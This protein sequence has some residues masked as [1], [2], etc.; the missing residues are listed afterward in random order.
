MTLFG[1]LLRSNP[2][3]INQGVNSPGTAEMIT[4]NPFTQTPVEGVNWSTRTGAGGS[5]HR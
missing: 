1:I 4:F 3:N 5:V 2:T